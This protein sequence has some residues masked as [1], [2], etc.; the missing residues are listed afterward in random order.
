MISFL[1]FVSPGEAIDRLTILEIKSLRLG[2]TVGGLEARRQCA[3]MTK[4]VS[5][6]IERPEIIAAVA[7]LRSAN[8]RVYEAEEVLRRC[9]TVKEFGDCF[10]AAAREAR[11]GNE[12]RFRAKRQID[13]SLGSPVVEVKSYA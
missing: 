6:V 13:I 1:I 11:L 2:E 7:E 10:V 5:G 9:E 4:T 12:A 8:A 3:E